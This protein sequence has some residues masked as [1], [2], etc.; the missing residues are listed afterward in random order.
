VNQEQNW[1]EM[2][3][4]FAAL[5]GIADNVRLSEGR[6][7]RGLFP[8]DRSKPIRICVP[9]SLLL[10]K[11]YVRFAGN[12]FR[13]APNAPVAARQRAFLENYERDFSWGTGRNDTEDLL[14]ML[15]EA[16][17]E[18]RAMLENAFGLGDWLVGRT[19]AA[20]QERF[21]GSRTINFKGETRV[22]PIIEL[23]NHGHDT[24]YQLYEDR[25][26][27]GGRFENEI[28]VRYSDSDPLG[29]FATWGF[30]SGT[31]VFALSMPLG[32]ERKSRSL[33]VGRDLER[34]RN[35]QP[36]Q[37]PRWPEVSADGGNVTLSHA[38]LGHKHYPRFARGMFYKLMRQAGIHDAEETFDLIQHL[39]RMQLYRLM[40]ES[41]KAAA[42]LG[43]LLRTVARYQL[44]CMSHSVGTRDF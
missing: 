22:M 44:E 26:E 5:G 35:S 28:L 33:R 19:P 3:R 14:A 21:L 1:L 8:I 30:A 7:G 31:E 36:H 12:E 16:P 41:E 25:L 40:E 17:A 4:E 9:E 27:L 39:N 38:L 24:S 18:L 11:K 6:F 15:A 32:L 20:V 29:I 2:V 42:R 10:P 37:P 34:A 13:V 43:N 23:A